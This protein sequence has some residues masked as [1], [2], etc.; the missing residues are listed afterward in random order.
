MSESLFNK[1]GGPFGRTPT[2]SIPAIGP[3]LLA[4]QKELDPKLKTAPTT[5]SLLEEV[6]EV[7]IAEALADE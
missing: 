4:G 3:E 1:V 7:P 5:T 2:P 6:Q